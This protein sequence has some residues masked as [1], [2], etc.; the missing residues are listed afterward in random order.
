MLCRM[1]DMVKDEKSLDTV[2]TPTDSKNT[3]EIW[4]IIDKEDDGNVLSFNL[5]NN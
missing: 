2:M 5:V 4:E 1:K 3:D